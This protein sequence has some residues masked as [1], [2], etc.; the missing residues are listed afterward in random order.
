MAAVS[1]GGVR[2]LDQAEISLV[3][4][5]GGVEGALPGRDP[6]ALAREQVQRV[7]DEWDELVEGLGVSLRPAVEKVGD[8][9]GDRRHRLTG[10]GEER[11][12]EGKEP[13]PFCT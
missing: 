8:R 6:E 10:S 2:G 3:D 7:V 9:S 1:E 5:P 12:A 4:Q 13:L 11:T